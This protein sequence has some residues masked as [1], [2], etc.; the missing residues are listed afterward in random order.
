MSDTRTVADFFAGIG[1][2]SLGL[3]RAGWKTVYALDYDQ[4]KAD[5]YAVNFD[6]S[7]YV[8]KDIAKEHGAN[9]PNVQ[10]AHASFPCTDLSVA[11][12]RRGIYEGESSSFWHFVRILSEMKEKYGD[13]NPNF[14]LLENV[15]G[16]LTS[17]NGKDLRAVIESLNNLG[18]RTDL[19]RINASHFVPQSR[20]RIFIVGIHKSL[21]PDY[22]QNALRQEFILRS[23]NA[24]PQ[25]IIDYVHKNN[26]LEWYFHDLPNLP[27][28]TIQLEEVIDE[29]AEWWPNQRTALLLGQLHSY[30]ED[31]LKSAKNSAE[32][33]YYP[34]FRRMRVRDGKKQ[35]TV[36][37]RTDG[38]AGCL[39]TPKGGS[40][41]QILVRAGKG[42]IDARL[43]NGKEAALLM[44]ADN[45]DIHP[46][47][48]LNQALFGFGDAV[49][50]S[51][52]QWIGDNYFNSI[53]D[54]PQTETKLNELPVL[55]LQNQAA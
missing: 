41:R 31:L 29:T 22:D 51:V 9:V 37:I 55:S 35:S 54:A 14:V 12:A 24:R 11:G 17:N 15:E 27:T 34:A 42:T 10:L 1:L 7:H 4:E 2:V 49:C 38:I 46:D 28:R 36:E 25:K 44:G 33:S 19:L 13:E 23:S 16:L 5:Q 3:D 8:M 32:Y 21:V 50:V 18:Y 48:S 47:F 30:H 53:S 52:L 20:V 26:D 45:Y 6:G 40:A 39:R 43:I